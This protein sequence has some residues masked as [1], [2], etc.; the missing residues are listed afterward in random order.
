MPLLLALNTAEQKVQFALAETEP[1]QP[2]SLL[3]NQSWHVKSGGTELLTPALGMALQRLK[4]HVQEISRIAVVVGP[5][6]FTGVRLGM[7]TAAGLARAHKKSAHVGQHAC[8]KTLQAPIDYTHLLAF[9]AHFTCAFPEGTRIGVLTHARKNTTHYGFFVVENNTLHQSAPCQE[10][11]L[12]PNILDSGAVLPLAAADILLGSGLTKNLPFF[13]SLPLRARIMPPLFDN[14]TP[15]AMLALAEQAKYAEADPKPL[16][17]R[18]CDAV[19]NLPEISCALGQ[20]P[21]KARAQYERLT[22]V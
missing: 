16:Y 9:S 12:A 8:Q 5:G 1:G 2:A 11:H 3:V 15:E 19:D 10:L 4:R 20:D 21:E 6:N 18:D 7:V 13:S 14:P 22:T 17:V